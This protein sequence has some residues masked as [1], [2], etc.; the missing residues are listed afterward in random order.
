MKTGVLNYTP[1]DIVIFDGKNAD[2]ILR[3]PPAGPNVRL[4]QRS[5]PAEA[6]DAGTAHIP[7]VNPPCYIAISEMPPV[8]ST[9]IVSQLVAEYMMHNHK[10]HCKHIFAPDTSPEGAVRDEKGRIMGTKRLVRYK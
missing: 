3:I 2:V 4:D 9:I 6:Y 10:S 7:C 5:E 8:D 1:H